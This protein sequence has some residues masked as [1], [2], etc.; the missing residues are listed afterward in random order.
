MERPKSILTALF[1]LAT[2]IPTLAQTTTTININVAGKARSGVV[3]VPAGV[4][5]PPVVFFVHGYGG[6][7]TGF[8]NDTKGNVVADREKFIAVYP[9]AIG[10]SWSMQDTADYPFLR[11]L[12]DEVDTRYKIDRERVYCAGFSQGGFISNGVGYKHARIF[13]AV[14]PVSGH[15]PS[16]S[17]AAPLPRPVP[18]LTTFGTK[19]ISDVASFMKDIDTWLKLNGCDRASAKVQ[20]PYPPGRSGSNVSRT[21]YK[22]AQG[23]EVAYDSVIGGQHGW[24]MDAT[25]SV[26][27]TEEAWAFFKRF[28]LSGTTS[29]S[30]RTAAAPF[31]AAYRDG[32][33]RLQGADGIQAVRVSDPSGRQVVAATVREQAFEFRNKPRGIYLATGT[34]GGRVHSFR[35]TIP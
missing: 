21:T 34:G 8:A 10:G 1:V 13:A 31:G 16:F 23:S 6:S 5:K 33:V 32:M 28:T 20:R 18:V 14:A 15:I 22:C 19:D 27:A 12:L 7:G 2:G 3:H 25:R 26:N 29:A 17:T 30:P 4:S 11:A 35:F 24:P 9:S